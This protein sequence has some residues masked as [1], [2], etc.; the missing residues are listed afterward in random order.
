MFDK[1]IK[2]NIEFKK[3]KNPANRQNNRQKAKLRIYLDSKSR[4]IY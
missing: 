3:R 1:P 2:F 4:W